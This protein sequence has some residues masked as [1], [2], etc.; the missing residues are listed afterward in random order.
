MMA[1][2]L[3]QWLPLLVAATTA[4]DG[5]LTLGSLA[6]STAV[7]AAVIRRLRGKVSMPPAERMGL[8]SKP[9]G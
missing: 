4:L 2:R 1:N 6:Q 3:G 9:P 7:A 5:W 8:Y